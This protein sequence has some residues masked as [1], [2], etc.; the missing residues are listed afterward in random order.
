MRSPKWHLGRKDNV[1]L[2]KVIWPGMIDSA[3]VHLANL[4][5]EGHGLLTSIRTGAIKLSMMQQAHLVSYQVLV[6]FW[7]GNTGEEGK[8][9]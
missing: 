6:L 9:L 3:S 2:D 8:L 4:G 5:A 1:E 7:R